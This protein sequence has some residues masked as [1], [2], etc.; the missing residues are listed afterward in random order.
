M[1]RLFD[2]SPE[3]SDPRWDA[4]RLALVSGVGP[5]TRQVLLERFGTPTDPGRHGAAVPET[6]GE[7]SLVGSAARIAAKPL[8]ETPVLSSES[9]SNFF[10]PL[11]RINPLSV[12][13][14]PV[15]RNSAKADSD[16]SVGI[17]ASVTFVPINPQLRAAKSN[18]IMFNP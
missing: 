5:R 9:F 18:F 4:L 7:P 2:H 15:S 12:T 11:R 6:K 1:N 16:P 10:S 8:L 13:L 17:P 3:D 14:A